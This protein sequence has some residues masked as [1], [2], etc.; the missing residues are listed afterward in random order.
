MKEILYDW[1]GVNVWLFHVIN[2]IKGEYLDQFMLLGTHIG[3]HVFFA[4]YLTIAVLIALKARNAALIKL[5]QIGAVTET[6]AAIHLYRKAGS[7]CLLSAS[8]N[9]IGCWKSNRNWARRQRSSAGSARAI[10]GS[11]TELLGL[12]SGFTGTAAAFKQ[13]P[14]VHWCFITTPES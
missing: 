11:G 1:G 7:V 3:S 12:P 5:N 13:R 8:P 10:A 14:S 6:V 4:V 9:T 2:D